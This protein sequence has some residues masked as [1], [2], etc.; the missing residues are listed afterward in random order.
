MN[1]QFVVIIP[2]NKL[3][4][5]VSYT[6]ANEIRIVASV[7]K[8]ASWFDL[9]EPKV[10]CHCVCAAEKEAAFIASEWNAFLVK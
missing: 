5:F 8:E 6:F 7:E 4:S 10:E 9:S 1:K 3:S 2:K